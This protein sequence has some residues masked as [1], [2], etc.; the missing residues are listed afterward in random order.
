MDVGDG[1]GDGEGAVDEAAKSR[2]WKFGKKKGGGKGK[3]KGKGKSSAEGGI[4]S[5]S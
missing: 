4:E 5:S 3:G 2:W 1:D